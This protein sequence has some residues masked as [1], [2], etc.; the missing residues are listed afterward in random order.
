MNRYPVRVA[1]TA[2]LPPL[3]YK[4]LHPIKEHIPLGISQTPLWKRTGSCALKGLFMAATFAIVY[5]SY[6]HISQDDAWRVQTVDFS[7]NQHVDNVALRHLT[8]VAI[9]EHLLDADLNRAAAGV[10]RHPW[11][12]KAVA[13][14]N[15]PSKIKIEV[16]EHKPALLLALNELWY[17]SDDAV[18]FKLANNERL[19][20]PIVTG[21]EHIWNSSAATIQ[22]RWLN[23]AIELL[24]QV[25]ESKTLD[26]YQVSEIHLDHTTG[27]QLILRNGSR[28]TLGFDQSD[29]S[30]SRLEQMVAS[31][32]DLSRPQT[33]DL[34]GDTVAVASPLS[35]PV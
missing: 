31:G 34:D 2:P 25:E 35:D 29:R 6:A 18:L 28:L 1:P 8:D 7:G 11:V 12:K 9:G 4:M 27:F 16:T 30:I 22:Q 32:L 14:R 33:I 13:T 21:L 15:Y 26:P 20:Y 10:E 17:I 24:T 23:H 19:D 3:R 5:G